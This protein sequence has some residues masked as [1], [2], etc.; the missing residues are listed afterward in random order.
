MNK[1]IQSGTLAVLIM[2]PH[3]VRAA[4]VV[5]NSSFE[6]PVLGDDGYTYSAP[7]W[8]TPGSSAS[9]TFNPTAAEISG[10][11]YD[12]QNVLYVM[13]GGFAT[14]A[15][16]NDLN[17][18]ATLQP[19]TAYIVT[20]AVGDRND[21]SFGGIDLQIFAGSTLIR[22]NIAL[23]SA[24]PDNG[25]VVYSF[26]SDALPAGN[27]LLGQPL[28]ITLK[29][30]A[31]GQTL[32]DSVSVQGAA[33]ALKPVV[34]AGFEAL[35]N[36]DGAFYG[37]VPAGWQSS[38][39]GATYVINPNTGDSTGGVTP[40]GSNAALLAAQGT[41]SQTSNLA[42]QK[43]TYTVSADF[44]A[45]IVQGNLNG[46]ATIELWDMTANLLLASTNVSAAT[47]NGSLGSWFTGTFTVDYNG[48]LPG[49]TALGDTLQLRLIRGSTAGQLMFDNVHFDFV[50]SQKGTVI[51]VCS[52]L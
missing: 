12:G 36:T 52:N 17:Q 20:L 14:Q 48:S 33:S 3:L 21:N 43:G 50:P 35:E 32:Y 16:T 15:L 18:A 28:S 45:R 7:G 25:Y 2:T 26:S 1:L 13:V 6:L 39:P 23:T 4:I 9:G 31:G 41:L 5:T 29:S 49:G 27:A 40:E 22:R 38:N 11:A 8:Q 34:N 46:A 42:L 30:L 10:E 24:P 47:L 51:I 19:N 37:Q 44:A